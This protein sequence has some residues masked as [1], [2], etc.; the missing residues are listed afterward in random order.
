MRYISSLPP[1]DKAQNTTA[2]RKVVLLGSTGSIGQ[3]ACQVIA[4]WPEMFEICGLAAGQNV[5][6]LAKQAHTW[7]PPVLAVQYEKNVAELKALLP[8]GYAPEILVGQAGY[9]KM[10]ALP[11]ADT[12]LAAQVGAAGLRGALAAVQ[13]GKRVCLANKESLVLAGDLV[14]AECARSGASILPVDSEHFALFTCLQGRKPEDVHSLVLTASGG[15]FRGRSRAELAQVSRGDA[16]KHPNWSMGAK[17]TIDSA[18]LMNKG[19]EIIEACHLYGL[20]QSRVKAVVHPQSLVH[21]LVE[22]VDGALLAHISHP[23]MR[24]PIA[25]CLAWPHMPLPA[26]TGLRLLE[27]AKA[28]TLTFEEPDTT[29]FSCLNLARQAFEA[30][31]GSTVVLNAANEVAV[32]WFL[33]ERIGFLDIA[34]HIESAL[35][36]YVGQSP[37]L[38]GQEKNCAT[39]LERIEALDKATREYMLT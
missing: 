3:N 7:R 17:I 18:T 39:A 24:L 1:D 22:L 11:Q 13:A 9:A 26:H 10:A 27:L 33:K 16:L 25:S 36:W 21:S 35:N 19:L 30:S 6:E 15:P 32:D 23:D 37:W 2:T 20:P 12:V 38:T 28:G 5:A 29:V 8:A 14:R 31:P 34:D 4:A